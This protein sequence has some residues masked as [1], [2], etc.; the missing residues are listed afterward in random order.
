LSGLFIKALLALVV[1]LPF[2]G[3]FRGIYSFSQIAYLSWTRPEL[4]RLVEC[5][6]GSASCALRHFHHLRSAER[7]PSTGALR[8]HHPTEIREN[9]DSQFSL[10]LW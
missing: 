4:H 3:F 8:T 10:P 9:D 7:I 2:D 5:R 6:L 1:V